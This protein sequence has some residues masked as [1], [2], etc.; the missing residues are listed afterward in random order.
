MANQ[1]TEGI[2]DENNIPFNLQND[3][4]RSGQGAAFSIIHIRTLRLVC[5]YTDKENTL[6]SIKLKE[7]RISHKKN[8]NEH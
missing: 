3:N 2:P 1:K 7:F 5:K 4:N 8:Y 6:F